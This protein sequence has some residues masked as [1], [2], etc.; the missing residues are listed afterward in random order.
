MLVHVTTTTG[1]MYLDGD[2][3]NST[4][5]DNADDVQFATGVIPTAET[6]MTLESA[7]GSVVRACSLTLAAGAGIMVE[8]NMTSAG[9]NTPLVIDADEDGNSNGTLQVATSKTITSNKSDVTITAFDIDMGPRQAMG[10]SQAR[11]L[12]LVRV[13]PRTWRFWRL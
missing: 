10:P 9:A 2:F 7:T 13:C 3:E 5:E 12:A 1:A 6:V 11:A 4:T 8:D